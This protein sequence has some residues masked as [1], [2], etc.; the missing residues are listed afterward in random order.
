MTSKAGFKE[1]DISHMGLYRLYQDFTEDTTH[2]VLFRD[3]TL[4]NY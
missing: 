4:M 2:A 1:N 3:T